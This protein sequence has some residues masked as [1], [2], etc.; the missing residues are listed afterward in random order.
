VRRALAGLLS[1]L[2][3][4]SV[5]AA[6]GALAAADLS[7]RA[8]VDAT[9]VGL[10]DQLQLTLTVEGR[11]LD[12]T[13]DLVPPPL[14]N[15]RVVGGPFV[16]NQ[17]SFV[18]GSASQSKAYTWV[19]QPTAAG[20]AEVGSARAKTASGEK[21]T[22]AIAIE[23]VQGSIRARQQPGGGSPFDEDPFEALLGRRR[24]VRRGEPKLLVE[25]VPSRTR[26]HVGEP[27]LLTYYLYTQT[28]VTDLQF[29][30]PPQYPGFW[31]EDLERA[32]AAPSGEPATVDG[33]QYHRFAVLQKLL[34][35]T[36][37]GSLTI[38]AT[39]LRVGLARQSVFDVGPQAVERATKPATVTVEAI[40][41]TP[42]FSGAVGRFHASAT[43]DKPS[44]AFGDAVTVR[45]QV[46]GSGNLKW[47][48]HGPELT[49]PGAKVYA[50]QVTSA[51]K[52]TPAGISGS[53]TWEFVVVPQ[54][55][56]PLQVPALAFSYFDA[57]VGKVVTSETSPLT[58]QVGAASAAATGAGGATG[59]A[60]RPAAAAATPSGA[61]PL[62]SDLD[63]PSGLLPSVGGRGMA[64][65]LGVVALLHALL[66]MGDAW[67]W[68]RRQPGHVASGAS[69]RRA[70]AELARAEAGGL[71]KEASAAL[72][73]KTLTDVFGVL[74]DGS[75]NGA[76]E[77]ERAARAVLEDVRFLRY[78]PQLG[79]YSE[80]IREVA[81]R[82]ADV[83]RRWA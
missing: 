48:D 4:L 23:V 40:P 11:S 63:R 12:L 5:L 14:K 67:P 22:A 25:A 68:R 81:H 61:L 15:L 37:S 36:K 31:A 1:L 28:P 16:S 35:P 42:G 24:N 69:V 62:R 7:F 18:N 51:L 43:I 56:G 26:L 59:G 73:E 33:E 58:V 46:E 60:A 17:F 53:K 34:F 52:A 6:A 30:D 66:L 76:G 55:S 45:F 70:L 79:D 57:A 41:E 74:E 38:P 32:K 71:T 20:R 13:E 19:L 78:A 10:E 8:E 65:A 39:T 44:V 75:G 72:I 9:K 50:P 27:L 2:S 83:V 47:I 21:T 77:G 3:V 82:A 80:K 64:V 54:T 49:V 29:K